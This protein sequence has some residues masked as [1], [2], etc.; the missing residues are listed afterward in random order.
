[1]NWI[2]RSEPDLLIADQ[3][4][5]GYMKVIETGIRFGKKVLF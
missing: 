4:D 2:K 1:M 5:P 3:K